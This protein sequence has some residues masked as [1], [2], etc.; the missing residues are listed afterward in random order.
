VDVPKNP[1]E[2][3]LDGTLP[4]TTGDD[5]RIG[6]GTTKTPPDPITEAVIENV[7]PLLD[8]L[9]RK[10]NMHEDVFALATE[11]KKR[12]A[13]KISDIDLLRLHLSY[14]K[15]DRLYLGR[16]SRADPFDDELTTTLAAMTELLPGATLGEPK[17]GEL[18]ARQEANRAANTPTVLTARAGKVLEAMEQPDAPFDEELRGLAHSAAQPNQDDRLSATAIILW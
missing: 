6:F 4:P 18:I 17:V 15:L 8:A 11:L 7:R 10:G 14:Q 1:S 3:E 16:E 5:V 2:P 13:G 9:S 12:C